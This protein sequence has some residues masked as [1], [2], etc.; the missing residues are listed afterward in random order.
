MITLARN[1]KT[2]VALPVLDRTGV[3]AVPGI[4]LRLHVL[5]RLQQRTIVGR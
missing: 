2:H 5:A 4:D 3:V 1:S